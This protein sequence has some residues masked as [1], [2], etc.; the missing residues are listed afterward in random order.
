MGSGVGQIL[1]AA[2]PA[3]VGAATG[4]LGLAAYA[5][6]A[7]AATGALTGGLS[8]GGVPGALTG[9]LTGYAGGGLGSGL[10]GVG[11]ALAKGASL[12]NAFS[13][14]FPQTAA[15][16][17]IGDAAGNGAAAADGSAG[18]AALGGGAPS[19]FGDGANTASMLSTGV[20]S[21]ADQLLSPTVSGSG[22]SLW[23]G[24]NT[25]GN[26]SNLAPATSA[27]TAGVTGGASTMSGLPLGALLAGVGGLTNANAIGNATDAMKKM[28]Q[29]NIAMAAPYQALGSGASANLAGLLNPGTAATDLASTPGYQFEL[30]QGTKALNN[31]NAAGGMTG[32]GAALKA[33]QQFGQGLAGRTYNTA[34]N[35][36]MGAAGLG[37]NA[38]MGAMGANTNLGNIT[39]MGTLGQANNLNGTI[40]QIVAALGNKNPNQIYL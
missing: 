27:A 10:E 20:P 9:G 2:L 5:P 23:N 33:A 17:G 36:N 34:V 18:A 35:Q 6:L 40:A 8:G 7:G 14:G 1:E 15:S 37:A 25:L 22:A 38:T 13:A 31:A 30:Q 11:S 16:L 28:Q 21:Q 24:A 29:Q 4:G 19:A 3:V 12:G 39:G 32:S 26:V